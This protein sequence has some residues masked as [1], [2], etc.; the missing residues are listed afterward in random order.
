[1]KY[2]LLIS[3]LCVACGPTNNFCKHNEESMREFCN[4]VV[5]YDFD[6][7][8]EQDKLNKDLES[9][10]QSIE[11]QIK[12]LN[13][14]TNNNK[15]AIN[16][17]YN[18]IQNVLLAIDEDRIS[19]NQ[20]WEAYSSL[21]LMVNNLQND[22]L[23]NSI[24]INETNDLMNNL[25]SALNTNTMDIGLINETIAMLTSNTNNSFNIIN[26]NLNNTTIQLTNDFNGLIGTLQN[27]I[28]ENT[29]KIAQLQGYNNIIS[30]INPCGDDPLKY[31][32][33]FLRLSSGSIIAGFSDNKNG[34]NTRFSELK[35]GNYVT[36]D[37]TNCTF[38][39][40]MLNN[41]LEVISKNNTQTLEY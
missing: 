35:P 37:G 17:I 19:M 32:E 18:N 28:N 23:N 22:S 36:T 40:K 31:D 20:M 25:N 14:L 26:N 21:S 5:G 7:K 41:K 9:R 24:K 39:V 34:L 11:N 30:M 3:L 38:E 10:V 16:N 12:Y 13:I 29:Q 6:K 4:D 15:K 8:E 27:Q 33:I 2:I 1:M